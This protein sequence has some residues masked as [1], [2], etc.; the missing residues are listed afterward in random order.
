M[1]WDRGRSE[2]RSRKVNGRDVGEYIGG[3]IVGE[4]AAAADAE[5]RAMCAEQAALWAAE[6]AR[7]EALDAKLTTLDTAIQLLAKAA[8]LAA[9]YHQHKRQWRRKRV[10]RSEEIR[11]GG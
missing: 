8:L 6:R 4:A 7:L 5:R 11:S 9:G 10:R 1:G 3:G 2:P